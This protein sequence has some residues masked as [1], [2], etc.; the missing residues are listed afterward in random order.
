MSVFTYPASVTQIAPNDFQVR[1]GAFPEALTGGDTQEAAL[2][3]ASDALAAVIET[4]VALGRVLPP[5]GLA[6]AG[7]HAVSAH[8]DDERRRA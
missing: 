2:E 8:V 5:A 1:F 6:A 7:E 3:E 4:Y